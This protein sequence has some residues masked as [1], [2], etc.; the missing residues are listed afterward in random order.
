LPGNTRWLRNNEDIPESILYVVSG[1][2]EP[3]EV[4]LADLL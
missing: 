2:G 1:Q 3:L 4:C